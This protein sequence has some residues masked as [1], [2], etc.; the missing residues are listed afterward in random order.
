MSAGKVVII[1]M[2]MTMGIYSSIMGAI[3]GKSKVRSFFFGALVLP[4]LGVLSGLVVFALDSIPKSITS[5][6]D[7]PVLGPV[8]ILSVFFGGSSLV[9]LV[10]FKLI[11]KLDK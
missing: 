9:G 3:D 4:V 1:F 5:N 6:V 8:V 7:R 2:I 11:D 10:V